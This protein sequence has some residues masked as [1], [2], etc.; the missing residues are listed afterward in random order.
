MMQD[1]PSDI[2]RQ[3]GLSSVCCVLLCLWYCSATL[4]LSHSLPST[5]K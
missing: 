3:A 2:D 1:G 5:T 4:W